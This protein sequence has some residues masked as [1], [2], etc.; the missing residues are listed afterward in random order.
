[1]G[2]DR[3]PRRVQRVDVPRALRGEWRHPHTHSRV[4][5]RHRAP[6]WDGAREHQSRG[7]DELPRAAGGR[8]VGPRRSHRRARR[9]VPSCVDRRADHDRGRWVT[10]DRTEAGRRRAPCDRR[11]QDDRQRSGDDRR[12]VRVRH[13]GRRGDRGH[14]PVV[15]DRH[16]AQQGLRRRGHG[17]LRRVATPGSPPAPTQS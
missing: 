4:R 11:A 16:L 8:F 12:D 10:D 3:D 1:M 14:R 7:P 2:G 15:H 6:R 5:A 13:G 9:A 17:S